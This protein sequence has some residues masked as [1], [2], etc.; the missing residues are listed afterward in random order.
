MGT[1]GGVTFSERGQ[2][3][4]RF[5]RFGRSAVAS[6]TQIPGG[7]TTIVQSAGRT[8]DEI[9]L[10]VRVDDEDTLNDLISKVDSVVTL[11]YSGG[12]RSVFVKAIPSGSIAEIASP[13]RTVF[14]CTLELI[15][16]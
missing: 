15:G 1:L 13:S 9:S 12:T 16:R 3:G 2:G 5:Q 11:E 10:I 4:Q 14:E 7:T 8:A 6:I